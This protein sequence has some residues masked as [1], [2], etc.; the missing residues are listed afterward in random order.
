M[1]PP[2]RRKAPEALPARPAAPTLHRHLRPSFRRPPHPP[3]RRGPVPPA[4]HSLCL[5]NPPRPVRPL[6]LQFPE[7]SALQLFSAAL[8]LS[9]AAQRPHQRYPAPHRRCFL[10]PK[11]RWTCSKSPRSKHC[12]PAP[13]PVCFS[14]SQLL[15]CAPVS[16]GRAARRPPAGFLPAAFSFWKR[17]PTP[18]RF[19]VPRFLP[20]CLSFLPAF[21]MPLVLFPPLINQ[22]N[23]ERAKRAPGA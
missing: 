6:P 1:R 20:L 15:P 11:R 9:F 17:L 16:R 7:H 13:A 12:F 3:K 21:L 10:F 14:L 19:R 18:V 8:L 23:R 4:R 5:R 22:L 2:V